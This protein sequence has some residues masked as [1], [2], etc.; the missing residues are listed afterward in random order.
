MVISQ[1]AAPAAVFCS[2]GPHR[3]IFD[4]QPVDSRH[5]CRGSE[6]GT[7]LQP[8]SSPVA[9]VSN[10]CLLLWRRHS[11]PPPRPSVG[12]LARGPVPRWGLRNV[13]TPSIGYYRHPRIAS[14]VSSKTG[15]QKTT[16]CKP[17]PHGSPVANRCHVDDRLQ[18]GAT[19]GTPARTVPPLRRT[20]LPPLRLPSGLTRGPCGSK[21]N[22]CPSYGTERAIATSEVQH[23]DSI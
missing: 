14:Q 13:T 3:R 7:G 5:E 1:S 18:P 8:V 12:R 11:R 21:V 6:C 20:K 22:P 2:A 23:A 9:P 19:G 10:R 16:G 15:Q 4:F 17:V